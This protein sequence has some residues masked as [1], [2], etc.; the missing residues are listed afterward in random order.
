MANA[1]QTPAND[2]A[3]STGAA[4]AP[5]DETQRKLD[6]YRR[7]L[8]NT[9]GENLRKDYEIS[10]LRK[11][12]G[13]HA[14]AFELLSDL[15]S[16]IGVQ[17]DV[18][19]ILETV[20]TS[21]NASLGVDRTVIFRPAEHEG[22]YEPWFWTGYTEF[23]QAEEF[24]E[25]LRTF[26]VAL[27]EFSDPDHAMLVNGETE[28]TE[29]TLAL[30]EG[31]DLPFFVGVPVV[32]NERPIALIVSGRLKEASALFAPLGGSDVKTFI[33][34]A[35]L[36]SA[37]VQN[38]R[39]AVLEEM[40]RLKADFFANISHEFRTP[41]TLT[42]GPLSGLLL[43]RY[44]ALPDHAKDQLRAMQ[45]SQQRL[46]LLVNQLLDIAKTESGAMALNAARV[47]SMSALVAGRVAYFHGLA[48]KRDITL[49]VETDPQL[50]DNE[51]YVDVEKFDRILLNL[52]SNAMKFTRPGGKVTVGATV[53]AGKAQICV[54]DTGVGIPA[55]QLP[56]IFDR[57]RQADSGQSREF[58]GT[59]IGL[60]L[61]HEFVGL[62]GG[63]INVTSV[64]GR[65][66][67]FRVRI[68]IG[69]EHLSQDQIVAWSEEHTNAPRTDAPI[70]E[71][72][73]A[74][75]QS[76]STNDTEAV[77]LEAAQRH[78][79]ARATVLYVDD[80]PELRSYV[81]DVLVDDYNVYLAEDGAVGL[82]RA[83]ELKPD[84]ILSDLMMPKMDGGEFCAA[85]RHD[86]ELCSTPF[87]L[88]TA[89]A[90]AE[91]RVAGLEDGAD[92]YLG[93]PFVERELRARLANMI[94]IRGQEKRLSEETNAAREIQRILLPQW[95]VTVDDYRVE[96]VYEPCVELSGDFFDVVA[97][98]DVMWVYLVDVTSHGAAA[99]AVTML[100]K[101]MIRGVID[102]ESD[103]SVGTLLARV[104]ER[105][106]TL[107]LDYDAGI[108][109]V[110]LDRDSAA[111]EYSSGN[112]PPAMRLVDG[113]A[114][115][116][117]AV[118]PGPG[119]SSRT[120]ADGH[121]YDTFAASL[122]EGEAL[123]IYTDGCVEF[124]S[125]KR[126]F[127]TRRLAQFL[128]KSDEADDW[129]DHML[130]RLREASDDGGF[131]DDITLIRIARAS[132]GPQGE[133]SQ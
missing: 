51:I 115:Q 101:E 79:D 3:P 102:A 120:G 88:L 87:I 109:V 112:A 116:P 6:Y 66:T 28:R 58:A 96:A 37:V 133:L 126:R 127:G 68:P 5:P 64:V 69:A 81:R 128:S 43:D 59:G 70:I 42:L 11:E 98:D 38:M 22:V 100:I 36:V 12:I 14:R 82:D 30:A 89:K 122:S 72:D 91:D 95:P 25:R 74:A 108:Q 111:F 23:G 94:R 44:G 75:A 50:D 118:A 54:T 121:H 39:V 113:S 20:M 119:L 29:S 86:S 4:A 85:V 32:V 132:R 2:G 65:G 123:Y 55:E 62:H 48:D 46:L 7:L 56:H 16:R 97:T 67:T 17:Q 21:I 19:E 35:G 80:N 33:A 60:A 10:S 103:V 27:P 107:G 63:E 1:V 110:R 84:L 117:I 104:H 71:A 15:Q 40:H 9:A 76:R 114:I 61:V 130:G 129:A 83:R 92:D 34:L 13:N 77:N 31:L 26:S 73:A 24:E 49:V 124:D 99:A 131:E 57:F 41:I 105:Y 8:D 47:P 90:G 78:D 53:S 18:G 106:A 52:L 93:K 125:K 45:S